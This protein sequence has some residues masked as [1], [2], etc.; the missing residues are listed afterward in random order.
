MYVYLEHAVIYCTCKFH[1]SYAMVV[2]QL[3]YSVIEINENELKDPY[4]NTPLNINPLQ[5]TSPVNIKDNDQVH[6]IQ[7]PR[8]G[9]LSLSSS[10]SYVESKFLQTLIYAVDAVLILMPQDCR[11]KAVKIVH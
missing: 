2:L 9:E 7:H 8:G 5:L 11:S 1:D 3:D 4:T 6:V 10:E